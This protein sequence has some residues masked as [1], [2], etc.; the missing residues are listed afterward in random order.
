MQIP[1][2]VSAYKRNRGNLPS[3]ELVNVFV[4]QSATDGKGIILQSRKGL[5]ED[6]VVG[7]GPIRATL[8][9]AGV[10]NGDR[11]TISG[12]QAY[13]GATLLG[14][15]AGNGVA[16]I[17]ASDV[18]VLFNAGEGIYSYNGTDFVAVDFLGGERARTIHFAN[19][20]FIALLDGTGIW[21]FSAPI[22]GRDWDGADYATAE[23][24]PDELREVAS[25]DGVLILFG[26]ESVEFW[27]PTGD[28]ELPYTPIQQRVFEQGIIGTGCAV[29][30]D[31]SFFWIGADKITYR[32]GDVPQAV[33]DD[34]IVEKAE[35]SE[36]FRLF[37][38]TDE[39]HK[40]L[41]QRH[42]DNTM[43][44][45]VTT[46]QWCE[47]K[48][49]GR[50]NFRACAG[51]GDDETGKIWRWGGYTDNAGPMERLFMAGMTLNQPMTASNVRITCEVGTTDNA[52]YPD[53]VIE[54]RTSDDAGATWGEWE[55]EELGQ[56]GFYRQ[57]VEWRALG[58]FD[59]P[60][61]L[62]QWRI[63]DPVSFRLSGVG[64]NEPTGGRSR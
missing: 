8:Q 48:S 20:R 57:R 16:R 1:Y 58:M 51:F 19:N 26:A 10:F 55:S 12:S 61:F 43:V 32:N 33:S 14:S 64:I 53:P 30:V 40:F 34:G 7:A 31:N 15:V 60:G 45:D 47:F 25:L 29:V 39:R 6:F 50:S 38:L 62:A 63:T 27:G 5:A 17:V 41:C 23:N 13:R 46:Q 54:M 35:A 21:H 11:F 24:E 36:S 59:D 42:D 18:E 3:L 56:Q 2:G 52:Q 4:E 49:L 37:L 22:N 9:K 44:L 28:A